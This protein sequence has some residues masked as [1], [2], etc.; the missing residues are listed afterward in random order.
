MYRRH[1]FDLVGFGRSFDGKSHL[2]DLLSIPDCAAGVVHDLLQAHK[3]ADDNVPGG[4]EKS[5]TN[6]VDSDARQIPLQN[7]YS[8]HPAS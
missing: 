1:K 2:D 8:D 3:T 5:S 4:E 7:H 6:K